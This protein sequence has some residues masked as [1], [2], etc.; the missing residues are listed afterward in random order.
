MN[1]LVRASVR[2]ECQS[3]GNHKSRCRHM[4]GRRVT[5]TRH[6]VVMHR[7][8]VCLLCH[9]CLGRLLDQ[10]CRRLYSNERNWIA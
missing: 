4:A 8:G 5:R 6:P 2:C 1:C 9:R 3:C 7:Y 10:E